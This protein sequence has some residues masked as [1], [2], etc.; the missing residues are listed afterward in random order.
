MNSLFLFS[1]PADKER[2]KKRQWTRPKAITTARA[3]FF[4]FKTLHFGRISYSVLPPPPPPPHPLPTLNRTCPPP[5]ALLGH[6]W[7]QMCVYFFGFYSL[8]R[9]LVRIHRTPRTVHGAVPHILS[10]LA[11]STDIKKKWDSWI[12]KD[13]NCIFIMIIRKTEHE[14]GW[15]DERQRR[16]GVNGGDEKN[17]P[18]ILAS[19]YNKQ[20]GIKFDMFEWWPSVCLVL[21]QNEWVRVCEEQRKKMV[22]VWLLAVAMR[23]APEC[24]SWLLKEPRRPLNKPPKLLLML[25]I[26]NR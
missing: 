14:R 19:T 26:T 3:L 10:L 15:M 24:I 11:L 4:R 23:A 5:L 18:A 1:W 17:G 8:I 2:K 21:W 13:I 22:W 20:Y 6:K 7:K 9:S 25:F 12:N 16:P